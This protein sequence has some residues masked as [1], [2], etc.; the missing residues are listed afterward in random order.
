MA[1][2]AFSLKVAKSFILKMFYYKNG[3]M[4][5]TSGIASTG[6]VYY[7]DELLKNTETKNLVL[8]FI[9]HVF[10]FI[11]YFVFSLIDLLTGLWNAKHQNSISKNPKK[12][13]SVRTNFGVL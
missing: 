10:G 1:K 9:V 7:L 13:I 8:P 2:I 11:I 12:I 3:A 6:I 4:A 5:A